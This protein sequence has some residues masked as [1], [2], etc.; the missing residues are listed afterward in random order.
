MEDPRIEVGGTG[1]GDVACHDHL[2]D[3]FEVVEL[4]WTERVAREKRRRGEWL[5]VGR[6]VVRVVCGH[7]RR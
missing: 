4:R 3:A 2:G 7:R 6:K 5:F 1:V